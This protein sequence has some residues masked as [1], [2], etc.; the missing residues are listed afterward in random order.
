MWL[1]ISE[2]RALLCL[3]MSEF[4]I[5]DKVLNMSHTAHSAR[6]QLWKGFEYSRIPNILYFCIYKGYRRFKIC[7]NMAEKCL[8][9]LFW[10]WQD[11]ECVWSKF[12]RVLNMPPVLNMPGLGIWQGCEYARVTQGSGYARINLNMS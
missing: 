5:I 3:N 4:T 12:H 9:N 2:Y 8:N 10:L 11:F 1:I 6:M 7:L